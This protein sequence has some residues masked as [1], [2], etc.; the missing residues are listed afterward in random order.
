MKR[1]VNNEPGE[2]VFSLDT[3]ISNSPSWFA[4]LVNQIRELT[5]PKATV[6]K[7]KKGFDEWLK[8]FR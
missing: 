5:G 7:Y 8:A 6:E 3:S 2:G 4:S 1:N